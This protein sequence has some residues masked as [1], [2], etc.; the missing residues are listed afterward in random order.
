MPTLLCLRLKR[1]C[2]SFTHLQCPEPLLLAQELMDATLKEYERPV[3]SGSFNECVPSLSGTKGQRHMAPPQKHQQ[4]RHQAQQ[5]QHQHLR[6]PSLQHTTGRC[7]QRRRLLHNP[8][9]TVCPHVQ[10]QEAGHGCRV[11]AAQHAGLSKGAEPHACRFSSS[12]VPEYVRMSHSTESAPAASRM[13]CLRQQPH[14]GD[15]LQQQ[16]VGLVM[17]ILSSRSCHPSACTTAAVYY[18]LA[19]R[20]EAPAQYDGN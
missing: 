7:H 20:R 2:T 16:K 8:D 1:S 6:G 12:S 9:A 5:Q 13:A 4:P 14:S 15:W 11:T 3:Y 17:R 19:R 10:K 18:L